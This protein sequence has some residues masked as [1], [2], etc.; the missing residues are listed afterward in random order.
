MSS[1]GNE[2]NREQTA[3]DDVR[4]LGIDVQICSHLKGFIELCNGAISHTSNRLHGRIILIGHI[5]FIDCVPDDWGVSWPPSRKMQ[6][7]VPVGGYGITNR[8]QSSH[9]QQ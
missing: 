7:S 6:N 1:L 5:T 4:F 2:P 9:T 8:F 3:N